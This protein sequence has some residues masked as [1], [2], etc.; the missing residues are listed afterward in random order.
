MTVHRVRTPHDLMLSPAP[1]ELIAQDQ[2]EARRRP[3][4]IAASV[5]LIAGGPPLLILIVQFFWGH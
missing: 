4:W 2:H 5:L 1:A 3:H